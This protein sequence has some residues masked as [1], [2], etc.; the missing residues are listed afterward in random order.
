M[1]MSNKRSLRAGGKLFIHV[2]KSLLGEQQED[3]ICGIG[4]RCRRVYCLVSFLSE[5]SYLS[6]TPGQSWLQISHQGYT[7]LTEEASQ[8]GQRGS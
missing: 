7:E 3:M 4:N 1:A 5:G 2:V 8:S 6:K